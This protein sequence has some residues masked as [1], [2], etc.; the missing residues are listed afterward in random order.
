MQG[1]ARSTKRRR[2]RDEP[3]RD[4]QQRASSVA[5]ARGLALQQQRESVSALQQQ[6][7]RRLAEQQASTRR[8]AWVTASAQGRQGRGPGPF[9]VQRVLQARTR[10]RPQSGLFSMLILV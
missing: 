9:A 6:R 7:D 4:E 5:P 1:Q 3:Q 2:D 8:G 10:K